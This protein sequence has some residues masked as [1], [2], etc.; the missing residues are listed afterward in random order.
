[1]VTI[2][3][4][5]QIGHRKTYSTMGRYQEPKML[6][7]WHIVLSQ[8]RKYELGMTSSSIG[9]VKHRHPFKMKQGKGKKTRPQEMGE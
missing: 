1:M 4:S 7:G 6:E 2:G 3:M 8:L 9:E 5:I